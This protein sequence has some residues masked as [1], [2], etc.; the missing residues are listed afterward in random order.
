MDGN[1][2][3]QKMESL[4]TSSMSNSPFLSMDLKIKM[5]FEYVWPNFK[6][7]IDL[8]YLYFIIDSLISGPF[9]C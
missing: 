6:I 7:I 5:I 1:A 3:K 4:I 9:L 2:L 8:S